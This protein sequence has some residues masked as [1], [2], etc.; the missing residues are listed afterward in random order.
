M[1]R[2][3]SNYA[4]KYSLQKWLR[5][6]VM[7]LVLVETPA[8][9]SDR[10]FDDKQKEHLEEKG[11]KVAIMESDRSDRA[12]GKAYMQCLLKLPRDKSDAKAP[13]R[14]RPDDGDG[15]HESLK[16]CLDCCDQTFGAEF[17][18]WNEC[19]RLCESWGPRP[20]RVP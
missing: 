15:D 16:R 14:M 6:A 8:A 9:A 11:A 7:I 18:Y 19:S 5:S 20:P 1:N 2:P 17:S 12:V 13:E 4:Q 10:M 3:F